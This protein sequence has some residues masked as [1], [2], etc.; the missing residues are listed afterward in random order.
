MH[1]L[2]SNGFSLVSVLIGAGIL[3][4][5]G[6]VLYTSMRGL[7]GDSLRTR[8]VNRQLDVESALLI[9]LRD[10]N[11]YTQE[12]K[13]NLKNQ[14]VDL[15]PGLTFSK[16]G[17]KVG[18]VG[19]TVNIDTLTGKNCASYG[20]GTC[21]VKID[22]ALK[23]AGGDC[24]AA[25]RVSAQIDSNQILAPLGDRGAGVLSQF[26][27]PIPHDIYK[28][29]Q[30]IVECDPA[31]D[32][33]ATG[34]VRNTGELHCL[35]KPQTPCPPDSLGKSIQ[36]DATQGPYGSL[37]VLCVP[38]QVLDCPPNYTLNTFDPSRLDSASRANG[39]CVF[40]G[41]DTV[42]WLAKF[43]PTPPATSITLRACPTHYNAAVNSCYL[44]EIV[45]QSVTCGIC[46]C[47]CGTAE[48]PASCPCGGGETLAPVP[49]KEQCSASGT[50]A[51]AQVITYP[52]PTCQCGG[53][54]PSWSA[55][56][57]MTG[58]CD[59]AEPREVDATVL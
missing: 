19:S 7:L 39:K 43:N 31:T 33:A 13:D 10:V 49:G 4:V 54:S 17:V 47:A 22:L 48:A 51:S 50:S 37:E 3:S 57:Q 46:Y 5:V 6:L 41:M 55:K 59:L 30:N 23:C 58:R 32:L 1:R 28:G 27:V 35:L 16:E 8:V 44:V 14:N 9:A 25:Y 42:P 24:S 15:L 21:L 56:V 40:M 2:R 36:Y 26:T 18:V 11:S 34:F 38:M 52:Q 53:G 20:S 12:Q 29:K 45:S